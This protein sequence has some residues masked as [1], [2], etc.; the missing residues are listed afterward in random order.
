MSFLF[1]LDSQ[2]IVVLCKRQ[3]L[4]TA[5]S[6]GWTLGFRLSPSARRL[7]IGE[8]A[9]HTSTCGRVGTLRAIAILCVRRE[10]VSMTVAALRAHS[11]VNVVSSWRC[12]M[13]VISL[14]PR[15]MYTQG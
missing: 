10:C 12:E 11:D 5:N 2:R 1:R 4:L 6:D 3:T 14:R 9:T 15:N 7:G 8:E 13:Y